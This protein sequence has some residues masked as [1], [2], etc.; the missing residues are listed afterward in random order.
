MKK[1]PT[2]QRSEIGTQKIVEIGI[3]K[4]HNVTRFY[5]L[6]YVHGNILSNTYYMK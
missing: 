1:N 2:Q 3:V 6:V 5:I 4:A